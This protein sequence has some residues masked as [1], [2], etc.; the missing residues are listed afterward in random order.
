M[1]TKPALHILVVDDEPDLARGTS[2]LLEQAGFV[3]T[4]AATGAEALQSLR[5]H[6]PQIVLLDR[7]WPDLDG[8]EICRQIKAA[9][10]TADI[11]VVLAS[12][13]HVGSEAQLVGLE[14]GADGYIVRPIGN[15]ELLARIEAF[16]RIVRLHRKLADE[17]AQRRLLE[18]ELEKRVRLRTDELTTAN[19]KLEESRRAAVN[20]MQDATAA[21]RHL[22][23]ANEKLGKE[24]AERQQAEEALQRSERMFRLEFEN[25]PVGRCLVSLDGHFFRTNQAFC[26]LLGYTEAELAGLAFVEVTHPDDR[27]ASRTVVA[28]LLT[29]ATS[30]INLEK[31]YLT[32]G[33]QT[34][35]GSVQVLIVRDGAGTPPH[36]S[37][38]I[39]DITARKRIEAELLASAELLID[40]QR[41]SKIGGWEWD[42]ASQT[43]TWTQETYRIH[44]LKPEDRGPCSA[45][46]IE[47]SAACYPAE[48]RRTVLE[49]FQRCAEHG[50]PYDLEC[51]FTTTTGRALWVRTTAE[52]VWE[53]SRIVQVVGNIM[54]ITERK[55]SEQALRASEERLARAQRA[56]G[57]GLWDWDIATGTTHWSPELFFIF[58]LD[59]AVS[60][61]SLDTWRDIVHPE[62]RVAAEDLIGKAVRDRVRLESDYRIVLPSGQ[63]RWISAL[64]E[65]TYDASGRPLRMAG[66]C[67]D[68][69]QRKLVESALQKSLR[70]KESLLKEI[71]HRVKNNLQVISSLLRLQSNKVANSAAESILLEMQNR[72]RSMALI[73]EHLY[74]SENLAEVDLAAY[75][76]QL[77]QQLFRAMAPAPGT[78][79][80]R[81]ETVPIR[82]GIDQAI[83]CGLLVNEMFS[84]ALKHAFPNGRT[85]QVQVQLQLAADSSLRLRVADNGVGLPAGLD[86][87]Q[88]N[89]LGLQLISDLTRQLRGRLEIG[90][91]PGTSFEVLFKIEAPA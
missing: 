50:Q 19:R 36:F 11:F 1:N 79:Q 43:M 5:A 85:G 57:A 8:L 77:C 86:L 59:S 84:N 25:A 35:W 21:Q 55:Q 60:L 2:R 31:R 75:L 28:Q 39:Q 34:V 72:V 12:G 4:V 63:I 47:Q 7:Q 6:P 78:I 88:L 3:V 18:A 38:H 67:L 51:P 22:A 46:L 73:H 24:F 48:D 20:L 29:G 74:R 89:S 58:G 62:D 66:I 64:G 52:A 9:P 69:T 53:G 82:L 70:E 16:A 61:A 13:V 68:A 81:L 40:T 91:G 80:L 26:T 17:V 54:D 90:P 83:P 37:V 32:K 49:A 27:A 42:I 56:A 44:D 71:H 10:A 87:K 65:T 14:T 76:K 41:L 33:G 45:Q 23:S 15:R 30:Q